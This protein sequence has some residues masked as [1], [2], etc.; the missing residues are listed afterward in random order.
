M[1]LGKKVARCCQ[2]VAQ[3]LDG[4]IIILFIL[5][6]DFLHVI[7]PSVT[8]AYVLLLQAEVSFLRRH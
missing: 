6:I 4:P 1:S 7:I 8:F 5:F 2:A 3:F